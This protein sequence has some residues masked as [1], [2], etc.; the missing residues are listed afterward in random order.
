MSRNI[1]SLSTVQDEIAHE[2]GDDDDPAPAS[3]RRERNV[4]LVLLLAEVESSAGADPH[5]H[6]PASASLSSSFLLHWT[7]GSRAGLCLGLAGDEKSQQK[8]KSR[9]VS[10]SD[11]TEPVL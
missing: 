9:G 10:V 8:T 7:A 4:L 6:W 3:I 5:H 11:W 1:K 2:A